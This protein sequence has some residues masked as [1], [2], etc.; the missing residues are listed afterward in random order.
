MHS[1]H[2]IDI[3][4]YI[5]VSLIFFFNVEIVGLKNKHKQLLRLV[6]DMK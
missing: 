3:H 2:W 1:F 6:S 5:S 4:I